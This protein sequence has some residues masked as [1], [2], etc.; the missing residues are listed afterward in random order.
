M[1]W[2]DLLRYNIPVTHTNF[3]GTSQTLAAG[4][5]KRVLQIPQEASLSGMPLNPR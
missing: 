3:N 5:K 1:R 2:F 4:D